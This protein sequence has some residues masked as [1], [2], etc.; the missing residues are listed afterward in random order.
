MKHS[1]TLIGACALLFMTLCCH[2]KEQSI[3]INND[4]DKPVYGNIYKT[5]AGGKVLAKETPIARYFEIPGKGCLGLSIDRPEKSDKKT[6]ATVYHTLIFSAD[7]NVL[8]NKVKHDKSNLLKLATSKI[9]QHI[10]GEAKDSECYVI[11]GDKNLKIRRKKACER[12]DMCNIRDPNS[13]QN[14]EDLA[15]AHEKVPSP[16][17]E[18]IVPY[19]PGRMN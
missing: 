17:E 14:V 19:T 2:G 6:R 16:T 4:T 9:P 12:L 8:Y 7:G 18:E 15:H 1:S 13:G 5:T 11:S 10:I 3:Y